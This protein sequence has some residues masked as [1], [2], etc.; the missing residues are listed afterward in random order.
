MHKIISK[1][2][3]DTM[4]IAQKLAKHLKCSDIIVLTGNLGTGKTYFTKGILKHFIQ[5]DEV[6]SPTFTIVNE[7]SSNPIIYHF[8]VYRLENTDE[9][10]NIG[11]EEYF[12]NGICIIEWGERISDVLPKE[13]LQ[14]K[15][16]MIDENT[17]CLEFIPYG[18]KYE[19]YIKEAYIDENTS[20]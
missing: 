8:D 1:N 13:F 14:I 11:G 6:S 16:E 9:F 7:Y 10:I 5:I 4:N 17:R 18:Q 19:N 3:D 12:Q 2:I 15:F 20:C